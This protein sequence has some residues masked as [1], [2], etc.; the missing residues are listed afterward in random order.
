MLFRERLH[1][2]MGGFYAPVEFIQPLTEA[3]SPAS[4]TVL[5]SQYSPVPIAI[6][7]ANHP[8]WQR[9]MPLISQGKYPNELLLLV[10]LV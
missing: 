3:C 2:Q 5:T 8:S 10:V 7:L 9:S 1:L 6:A 4:E